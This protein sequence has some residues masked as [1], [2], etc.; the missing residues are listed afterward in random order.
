MAKQAR[1]NAGASVPP[2]ATVGAEKLAEH[3]AKIKKAYARLTKAGEAFLDVVIDLGRALLGAKVDVPP[4]MWGQFLED[5]LSDIGIG[6]T[7]TAYDYMRV[8]QAHLEGRLGDLQRAASLRQIISALAKADGNTRKKRAG[9]GEAP[10]WVKRFPEDLEQKLLRWCD[11]HGRFR[12]LTKAILS[13]LT[14]TDQRSFTPFVQEAI[15]QIEDL[16]APNEPDHQVEIVVPAVQM[17]ELPPPPPIS[18]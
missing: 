14:E 17:L 3:V 1:E 6:S 9:S 13:G 16:F 8:A 11:S 2:E 5:N 10:G 18:A 4:G 15:R 12:E 7:R